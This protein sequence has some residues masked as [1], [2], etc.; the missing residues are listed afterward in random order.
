MRL[1]GLSKVKKEKKKN[2]KEK[3]CN[4]HIPQLCVRALKFESEG[5]FSP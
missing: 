2:K 3:T 1:P 4:P 5:S